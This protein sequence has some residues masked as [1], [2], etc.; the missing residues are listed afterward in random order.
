MHDLLV[1]YRSIHELYQVNDTALF[2][3]LVLKG[4]SKLSSFRFSCFVCLDNSVFS[5]VQKR[6]FS[7]LDYSEIVFDIFKQTI[8]KL[9][10]LHFKYFSSRFRPPPRVTP[11]HLCN[12]HSNIFYQSIFQTLD[13]GTLLQIYEKYQIFLNLNKWVFLKNKI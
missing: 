1:R 8:S 5:N 7:D 3:F 4:E 11:F 9:L 6:I 12:Y 2:E 10:I 13:I